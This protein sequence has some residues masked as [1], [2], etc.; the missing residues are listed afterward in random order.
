MRGTTEIGNSAAC[1]TGGSTILPTLSAPRFTGTQGTAGRQVAAATPI[2]G[3]NGVSQ[4]PWGGRG[5]QE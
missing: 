2:G 3:G 4:T 1:L 5:T